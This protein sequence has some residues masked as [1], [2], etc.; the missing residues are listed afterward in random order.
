[1]PGDNGLAYA[2]AKL[3]AKYRE[4]LLLKYANGYNTKEIA[5]IL[6]MKPDSVQ[7]LLWRAKNAL[8][9]IMEQEVDAT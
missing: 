2:M 7:K 9:K 6:D 5:K 3:P 8:G 1:M 4:V